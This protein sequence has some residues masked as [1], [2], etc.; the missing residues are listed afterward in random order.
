MKL[1]LPTNTALLPTPFGQFK[2]F[3]VPNKGA[4]EP[5]V[6]LVNEK[7]TEK[8]KAPLVRI[9]SE[10]LTGDIFQSRRCDCGEQLRL[11]LKLIGKKGGIIIYLRQ[12]GRGVGL[13]NKLRAYHLQDTGADTVEAQI[14]LRLPVDGRHYGAAAS[15]LKNLNATELRLLTNNPLKISDLTAHGIRVVARVPLVTRPNANNKKYL[16]T[17]QKK[18]GHLLNF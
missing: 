5:S 4:E 2:I 1:N 15:I 13:A 14:K 3:A 10:C 11:S 8:N 12:E 16:Q 18:L 6:V 17:K 9:H 7:F